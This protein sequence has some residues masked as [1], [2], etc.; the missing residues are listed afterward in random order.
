MTNHEAALANLAGLRHEHLL[1]WARRAYEQI[2]HIRPRRYGI[3]SNA[4]VD[5][6]LGLRPE[7]GVV[8]YPQDA[9]D[10]EACE[11]AYKTAPEDLQALMLPL[12]EKYQEYVDGR[13]V[14]TSGCQMG[15]KP[16]S[17]FTLGTFS[18][19]CKG[20]KARAPHDG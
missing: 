12:L 14:H 4:M 1:Y 3:S 8:L 2:H 20:M 15:D 10:L 9:Y 11:R 13:F 7:P 6:A 18:C 5:H 16:P 19:D 17:G